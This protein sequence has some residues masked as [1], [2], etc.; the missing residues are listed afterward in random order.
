MWGAR[1]VTIFASRNSGG[2]H[3]PAGRNFVVH[4]KIVPSETS[5]VGALVSNERCGPVSRSLSEGPARTNRLDRPKCPEVTEKYL[6]KYQ[7]RENLK[8]ADE[9]VCQGACVAL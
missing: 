3:V 8:G 4:H 6:T 5:L 1:T 7:A 2:P 9:K